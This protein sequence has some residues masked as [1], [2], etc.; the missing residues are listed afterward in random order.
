MTN[1]GIDPTI[2]HATSTPQEPD[3]IS[4]I[5]T[6][7]EE[8]TR[9]EQDEQRTSG[10]ACRSGGEYP[11]PPLVEALAT[12]P[13]QPERPEVM[14]VLRQVLGNAETTEQVI[15]YIQEMWE[16][17]DLLIQRFGL[18]DAHKIILAPGYSFF[19]CFNLDDERMISA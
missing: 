14:R 9:K 12:L 18:A 7:G 10:K 2:G 19:A 11:S 8:A 17:I 15:D 1:Q 5:G 3:R 4:A 6:E 16:T 13:E